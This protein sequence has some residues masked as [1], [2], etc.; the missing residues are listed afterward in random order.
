[1]QCANTS[2]AIA[3][4]SVAPAQLSRVQCTQMCGNLF[5]FGTGG[6]PAMDVP[7]FHTVTLQLVGV[8]LH[9]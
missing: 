4:K 3:N 9:R 2:V 1:M 7:F 6:V 5:F 8:I